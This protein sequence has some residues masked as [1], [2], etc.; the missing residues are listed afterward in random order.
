M[1]TLAQLDVKFGSDL[2]INVFREAMG[3]AQHH[4][5]VSGTEKQHV[6]DDYA[7][8]LA[9]G[10]TECA[11]VVNYAYQALL[12]LSN[13]TI[14][15]QEFCPFINVSN[16][17][18]TESS[19]MFTVTLYNPIGRG[20][21]YWVRI[22]VTGKYYSVT[23]PSNNAVKA[24]LFPISEETRSIPAYNGS[25]STA[26]LVF[27]VKLLPLGFTTYFVLELKPPTEEQHEVVEESKSD[28]DTTINSDKVSLTF[29]GSSGLLKGMKNLES[30]V[31][32]DLTQNLMYYQS[33]AGN[34]SKGIFQASGAYAFRPNGSEAHTISTT[35]KNT[36][37]KGKL[38]QEVR[39]VFGSWASQVVR[40]Y[41]GDPCA[42]FEFTVGPIPYMDKIGR[43]VISRFSTDLATEATFYT[44]ANGREVLKR[45]RDYRPTWHLNQTEEIAGNYYPV[46]SRIYIQDEKAGTQFTVL[47]D[48]SQ[49]GASIKDGQVEL[50]VHRR[51]FYDDSFGV[52]EPLNETGISPSQ[53]GLVIRGKHVVCLDTISNSGKLHRDRAEKLFMS[54]SQSFSLNPMSPGEY[55]KKFR[56][57]WSGLKKALPDNVHLLTLEQWHSNTYLLRLEHFYEK[58]DDP[59]LSKPASV[60]LKGLFSGFEIVS[61]EEYS[62]GG[63]QPLSEAKRLQWNIKGHTTNGDMSSF[64]TPVDTMSLTVTLDP[65]QIRTFRVIVN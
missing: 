32:S 4:D 45:V 54:P 1:D 15:L 64:V 49:G 41:M 11:E 23:D 24:E 62:L 9:R 25:K 58:T 16:C 28:D 53:K 3:V 63:N 26:E 8:R 46:N 34:N 36:V 33:F 61:V 42:E 5:A 21:D 65:M 14:L 60:Q 38:V 37:Y 12:P 6:A 50:M 13:D 57:S 40:L 59:V 48:R 20:Y 39:Q 2:K 44:D 51:M 10:A 47:T 17:H 35:S 31:T 43:E 27:Q 29:D 56:T 30:G 19:N 18:T 22:P 55:M 52:G 7:R